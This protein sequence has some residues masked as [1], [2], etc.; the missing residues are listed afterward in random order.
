MWEALLE[1]WDSGTVGV[2][3][4][5]GDLFPYGGMVALNEYAIARG[6]E[7]Q[8]ELIGCAQYLKLAA[9]ILQD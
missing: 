2:V 4:P 8:R 9:P 1:A 7:L 6:E 3:V 5:H